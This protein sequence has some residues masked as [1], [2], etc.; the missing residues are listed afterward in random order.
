MKL[1]LIQISATYGSNKFCFL[2]YSVGSLWSY[3]VSNEV[4]KQNYFLEDIFFLREDF[5]K[6]LNRL[7][8]LSDGLDVDIFDISQKVCGRI[9]NGVNTSELDELAA[10]LC[11]SM[12]IDNPDYGKLAARIIIS[13]HHKNTSPSFSETIYIMYNNKVMIFLIFLPRMA[14]APRKLQN[15]DK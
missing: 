5:D 8:H 13:N 12:M 4:V 6:V 7:K 3:A 15:Q 9:Y 2:P 1:Y 10:Q 11:S 14:P